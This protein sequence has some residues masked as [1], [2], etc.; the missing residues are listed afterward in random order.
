MMS[1]FLTHA[2]TMLRLSVPDRMATSELKSPL[3]FPR[4]D[5]FTLGI[6]ATEVSNNGFD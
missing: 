4:P 2:P 3:A 6:E 1:P 5:P